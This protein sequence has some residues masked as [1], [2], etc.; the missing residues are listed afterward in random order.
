VHQDT[1][2]RTEGKDRIIRYLASIICLAVA[3][4]SF[5]IMRDL[6]AFLVL[7]GV[8]TGQIRIWEAIGWS[9]PRTRAGSI[10][11]EGSSE[12]KEEAVK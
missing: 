9:G 12:G 4:Y 7:V 1:S 8:A 2:N 10:S 3:V 11:Q 5:W 6:V